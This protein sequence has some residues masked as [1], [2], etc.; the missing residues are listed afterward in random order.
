MAQIN[1][2]EIVLDILLELSGQTEYSNVLIG[3][4]LDKYDYLE[5]RERLSSMSAR[6]PSRGGFSSTMCWINIQKRPLPK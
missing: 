3:A 1:I 6:E 5:G 4:A 2:R